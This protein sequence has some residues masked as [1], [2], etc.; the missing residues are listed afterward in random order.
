V[1]VVF[2]VYALGWSVN[3]AGTL[4]NVSSYLKP[5]GR[6]VFSWEHPLFPITEF[7]D[8]AVKFRSPYFRSGEYE[9]T[10][11]QPGATVF[12]QARTVADWFS[13][14]RKGGFQVERYLE[15]APEVFSERQQDVANGQYYFRGRAEVVPA[16]MIFVCSKLT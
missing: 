10:G 5:G 12:M 2:S 16:T 3:L 9:E 7:A 15:P 11:W 1:D 14:L 4:G 13:E 6:F 8:G